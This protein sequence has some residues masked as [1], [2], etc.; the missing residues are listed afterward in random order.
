MGDMMDN[1]SSSDVYIL[2]A[3]T[4]DIAGPYKMVD[5][6]HY[7]NNGDIEIDALI[8]ID[9][10]DWIQIGEYIANETIET[11]DAILID[12]KPVQLL[13]ATAEKEKEK[14]KETEKETE[15]ET[16]TEKETT[17]QLSTLKMMTGNLKNSTRKKKLKKHRGGRRRHGKKGAAVP[18]PVVENIEIEIE[19]FEMMEMIPTL[20]KTEQTLTKT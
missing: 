5:V 17:K 11:E 14:E 4:N 8:S 2:S 10:S 20:K 9:G 1:G 16:E 13:V 3:E 15:T 7:L 18:V 12:I 6:K 19:N